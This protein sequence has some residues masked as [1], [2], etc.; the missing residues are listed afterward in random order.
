MAAFEVL[1]LDTTTPQIRA[2]GASDTYTF[3]R[4]VELP[5]GTANGVLYLDGSKVATSGTALS[6]DAANF[7]S[8]SNIVGG[9][10][11]V[12]ANI[13]AR[14]TV[15][16][17]GAGFSQLL[18]GNANTDTRGFLSYSHAA[19]ALLFGTIGTEQMRLNSTGLGIG[20]NNPATKLHIISNGTATA[21]AQFLIQGLTNTNHKLFIGFDTAVNYG[22]IQAVTEGAAYRDLILNQ[23]GGNVGIGTTS[24]SAPLQFGK[25]VYGASSSENFYR[26]KFED[27]G[28]V[29]NDVGIGQPAAGAMGFNIGDSTGY[30]QWN[31]GSAGQ[32]MLLDLSGNLGLGVTPSAWSG[33]RAFQVGAIG[34]LW[35]STSTAGTWLSRNAYYDGANFRYL[36]TTSS[37]AAYEQD[38]GGAHKWFSAPSGTVGNPITFSQVMTLNARGDLGIGGTTPPTLNGVSGIVSNYFNVIGGSGLYLSGN[39]YY[40]G[41]WK[42]YGTGAASEYE[43]VNGGHAFKTTSVSGTAGNTISFT[44]SMTLDASGRLLLGTTSATGASMDIQGS[45]SGVVQLLN[46]QNTSTNAAAVSRL[47]INSQGG[48]WHIDNE[49]NGA[50]LKFSLNTTLFLQINSS[51]SVVIGNAALTTTATEGFLYVPTCAGTP[52]G[53]P[54]TYTG[55]SPI[56][57][58]STNNKLY[59]YSGGSWRDA[60]P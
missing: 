45:A 29:T 12:N 31:R 10:G 42:Y 54:T 23:N 47:T 55:R 5:L 22:F 56:V 27:A 48:T 20:T 4:A 36:A 14:S 41:A 52:T 59:F 49:R 35:S 40:D 21:G 39:A 57:V 17:G 60:G 13:I 53:V 46:I 32:L 2:P 24:P 1:A 16:N 15:A 43:L 38:S 51:G 25:A 33:F 9:A 7:Y 8:A 37:A 11:N 30:Y 28:G 44:T 18:F 6:F 58:D 34:A 50:P 3:P 19:D 26:I